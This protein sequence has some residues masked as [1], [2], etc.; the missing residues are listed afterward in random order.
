M[1]APRGYLTVPE[2]AEALGLSVPYLYEL[3]REGR[4]ETMR[5]GERGILVRSASVRK[6]RRRPVGRPRK[7]KKEKG[8]KA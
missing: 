2:A 3:I 8:G 7:P 4:L 1:T 6:F 5:L